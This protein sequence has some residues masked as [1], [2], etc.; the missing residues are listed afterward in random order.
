[1]YKGFIRMTHQQTDYKP[2]YEKL[3]QNV[4]VDKTN[5]LYMN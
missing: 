1:M 3:T 4:H 5:V 2:Q